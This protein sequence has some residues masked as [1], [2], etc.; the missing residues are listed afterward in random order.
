M[1]TLIIP[2]GCPGMGKSY[3]ADQILCE[4]GIKNVSS[5]Q[6]REDLY[7]DAAIQ[8]DYHEV[9]GTVYD[10][11]NALFDSGEDMVILDATN[12]TRRVR[13]KAICDINPDEIIYVIMPDDLDRA[14]NYN[15]KRS[16]KVPERIVRRMYES[17]K[18][19]MPCLEYD[20]LGIDCSIYHLDNAKEKD[21]FYVRLEHYRYG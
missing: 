13:W 9:F 6:V 15:E 7:G 2:V 5:D 16:R 10:T 4:Y 17:Y 8:G 18:R 20:S 14:L 3:F 11:I 19:D 21:D 12:V 1:R